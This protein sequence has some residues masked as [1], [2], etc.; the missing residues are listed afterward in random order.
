M[1]RLFLAWL[2]ASALLT[3]LVTPILM[4]AKKRNRA[5]RDADRRSR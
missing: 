1:T 4:A 3:T 5:E 2:I